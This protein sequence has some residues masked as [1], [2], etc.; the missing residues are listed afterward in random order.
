MD[1]TNDIVAGSVCF[2][3]HE[4]H[5][6]NCQKKGCRCWFKNP[7]S[8]NCVILEARKGPQ[9]QEKIGKYFGLTRMRVCQI[10]KNI[11]ERIRDFQ[12]TEELRK[13]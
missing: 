12:E 1:N 13:S 2:E 10:E 3:A 7:S 4:K 11:L 6:L 9:K 8:Y 5:C